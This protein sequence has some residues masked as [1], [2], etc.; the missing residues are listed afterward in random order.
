MLP[1]GA[2]STLAYN[3]DGL[4]VLKQ[5]DTGTTKFVW[6]GQRYLLETDGNNQSKV[7]YTVEPTQFGSVISQRRNA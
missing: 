1:G 2:V 7:Q 5:D 6:D 3:G 4:R